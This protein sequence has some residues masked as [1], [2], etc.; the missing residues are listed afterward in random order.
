MAEEKK[1]IKKTRIAARAGKNPNASV[2]TSIDSSK[3]RAGGAK[4][5]A[6][7]GG[8][9][10]KPTAKIRYRKTHGDKKD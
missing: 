10:R 5:K 8:V 7:K 4:S 1:K 3:Y 9:I 6:K 2:E